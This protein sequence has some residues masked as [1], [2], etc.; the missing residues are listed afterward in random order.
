MFE[1]Y[2]KSRLD[3]LLKLEVDTE[4]VREH[5][6][7]RQNRWT[8]EKETEKIYNSENQLPPNQINFVFLFLSDF[9]CFENL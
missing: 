6:E 4:F 8:S 9:L 7:Y 1:Y 5:Y 3:G 2:D